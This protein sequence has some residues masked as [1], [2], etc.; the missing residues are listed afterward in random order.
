MEIYALDKS[1]N[2]VTVNIPYINLQWTRRYYEAGEFEV[3]IALKDYQPNWE[4]IASNDRKELG[5]IQKVLRNAGDKTVCLSGFF[6]EK[7]LDDE[8]C[9]PRFK[10]SAST[11]ENLVNRIFTAYKKDLPIELKP[12]ARYFGDKTTADFSDDELGLK[13]FRMLRTR[14]LSYHIR[15]DHVRNV[16]E[17]SVWSGKN[18]TQGNAENNPFYTFST[19][20]G[21]VANVEINRDTSNYKNVCIIPAAKDDKGKETITVTVNRAKRYPK[22]YIVLDKRSSKQG[23]DETL[24]EFKDALYQEGLEK[25]ASRSVINEISVETCG[26]AGYMVEYDLGDVCDVVAPELGI[27][28]P[29]RIV[30]VREVFK[31]SGHT[32]SL[33]FGE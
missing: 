30:E 11:T 12:N 2:T 14:G 15:Y 1:F 29:M 25:L 9:F 33:D 18:R 19:V 32:V 26:N 17:F 20:F 8:V 21:N 28:E 10:G 31:A 24:Q 7:K 22:R 5:M 6:Y 13:L 4:Y 27:S 3:Q 23:T 16:R